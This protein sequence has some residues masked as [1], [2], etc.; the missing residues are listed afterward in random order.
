VIRDLPLLVRAFVL[1]I[2]L[3]VLLR[4]VPLGTLLRWLEPRRTPDAADPQTFA[5]AVACTEALLWRISFPLR[6]VCLP[7][8]LT[9]Y[10][11]ARR[12][13]IPARLHCGVR[14]VDG[15][16]QG[17][18]WLSLDGRPFL[19]ADDPRPVYAVTFSFPGPSSDP[20]TAGWGVSS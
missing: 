19:E 8:S 15:G 17:H 20:G 18:A 12:C 13:G 2:A 1:L 16:F 14:R 5:R 10:H 11:F 7:R 6:G 3:R 9:L 4:L